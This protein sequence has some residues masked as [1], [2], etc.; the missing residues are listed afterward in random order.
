VIMGAVAVPFAVAL[1]RG[2]G[3]DPHTVTV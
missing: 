3:R 1:A 2:R